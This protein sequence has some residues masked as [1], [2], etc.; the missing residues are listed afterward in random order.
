MK[1][2][3]A[4]T[5]GWLAFSGGQAVSAQD[6][7]L[8][9]LSFPD[10]AQQPR[11]G[12]VEVARGAD[13]FLR[14]L[15]GSAALQAGSLS[16]TIIL[17]SDTLTFTNSAVSVEEVSRKI[18]QKYIESITSELRV[19][20]KPASAA[21]SPDERLQVNLKSAASLIETTN[22]SLD[23]FRSYE[24]EVK[25]SLGLTYKTK[26][27]VSPAGWDYFSQAI[28]FYDYNRAFNS[29]IKDLATAVDDE[30][31][32]DPAAKH[33]LDAWILLEKR[34]KRTFKV[35]TKGSDAPE[36]SPGGDLSVA[37]GTT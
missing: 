8:S 12:H 25:E 34:I 19:F 31:L 16:Q 22:A 11:I 33:V 28:V 14:A 36:A 29:Y 7:P 23:F 26:N 35:E 15:E 37:R 30:R 21:L 1:T 32:S 3:T 6:R 4:L 18:Y 9:E 10:N 24:H 27:G 13:A 17:G 5:I 20:E 2:T